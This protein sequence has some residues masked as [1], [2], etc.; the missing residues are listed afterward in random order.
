MDFTVGKVRENLS[1]G[2]T[3]KAVE[4]MSDVNVILTALPDAGFQIGELE[5]ELGI[6]PKVTVDVRI[7]QAICEDKLNAVLQANPSNVLL[8][9]TLNALLQASKLQQ[10]VS[11]ET[12]ELKDVKIAMAMT[13]TPTVALQWK[14]KAIAKPAAA[15]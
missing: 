7:G 14:E 6:T 1:K 13:A 8:S 9:A 5:V 10:A 11:V 15:A 3:D 4:L 2:M 12:L